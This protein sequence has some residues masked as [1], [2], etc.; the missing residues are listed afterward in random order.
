MRRLLFLWTL[1]LPLLALGQNP[2]PNTA[3]DAFIL[4][5]MQEENIPGMATVI[6]KGGE[7]VWRR[8]YGLADVAGNVPMTDSTIFA[9]AS[10]SKLFTGTA[11]MQLAED[12]QIDLDGPI[13]A[14]M[15]FDV[16]NP[17]HPGTAITFRMLMTHTSSI[18]DNYDVM[19]NYYSEGDPTI[20]LAEL[21][22]RYFS[23]SGADYDA[24]NNFLTSAPGSEFE[25]SNIA[26]ALAG[27]LVERVA[28]M[29]FDAF[30]NQ[31][32]FDRLC[33]NSTSWFLA[34]LD[35]SQVAK[36]H[37]WTG[38]QFNTLAHYGFADYPDGLLRS[39]V[40]DLANFMIAFLQQG[41]FSGNQLLSA[42]S[43][44]EMLSAQVSGDEGVMG[45][46][47]Y[48]EEIFLE[49]GGTV[50]MWGHN[51]GETGVSTDLYINPQNGIGVAVLNNGEGD[52]LYVVDELYNYALS[53][54]PSGA[55][56]PPCQSVS[57]AEAVAVNEWRLYPNPTTGVV[58]VDGDFTQCSVF[59]TD[60]ALVMEIPATNGRNTID[61]S[62]LRHGLY[63]VQLTDMNGS[64]RT[65]RVV[66]MD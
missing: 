28:Q 20:P 1:A 58:T 37:Q 49:D 60:G 14:H 65:E 51:G 38:S 40:S 50:M 52:N 5:E 53:L 62:G 3:L 39:N 27:Y 46:N 19:D 17:N 23:P 31:H 45:L 42:A 57:I 13:N 11:L 66:V 43:V 15:P 59:S 61:L 29:P 8:G 12:G 33:M 4:E 32:I 24:Q 22:E 48:P 30:C 2:N 26:T 18:Q 54:T 7:I 9:L 47:W 63:L 6:V 21:M 25:Y 44:A 41:T 56:N 16:V 34:G 10:V 64:A 55:G 36:P 35:V